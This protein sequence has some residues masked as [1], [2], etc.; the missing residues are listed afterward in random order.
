MS[1]IPGAH[2]SLGFGRKRV[3]FY[4]SPGV[5]TDAA[6]RR[7]GEHD[8]RD[9][10]GHTQTLRLSRPDTPLDNGETV[11]VLRMQS[12][13]DHDS[14]PVALINHDRNAWTRTSP[15]AT[16]ALGR[17]GVTRAVNWWLAMIAF[18]VA[19]L[20]FSWP[21]VR[22]FM[23]EVDPALFAS[24]PQLD[25]FAMAT[26][27]APALAGF[28]VAAA[29]PGVTGLVSQLGLP[30]WLTPNVL[31]FTLLLSGLAMFT[32]F[33]RSWRI[34]WVPVYILA[35][36]VTGLALGT[37]SPLMPALLALAG[38]ALVF[39]I[40]GT[41]NR[42]RDAARLEGRI[43]RLSENILRNPPREAVTAPAAAAAALAATAAQADAAE[44]MTDI[45]AEE[46]REAADASDAEA[47]GADAVEAD[48]ET[49]DESDSDDSDAEP[50]TSEADNEL[51]SDADLAAAR[52]DTKRENGDAPSPAPAL[53]VPVAAEIDD[54]AE[55]REM[56]LPPPPP[57]ANRTVNETG[58]SGEAGEPDI[59]EAPT[60]AASMTD[61]DTAEETPETSEAAPDIVQTPAEPAPPESVSETPPAV[62]ESS[63]PAS[64][65]GDESPAPV[66]A[67]DAEIIEV[68]AVDA[69]PTP[70]DDESD[71][72]L[73]AASEA[74]SGRDEKP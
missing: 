60:I 50:E 3:E 55:D 47:A 10:D 73:N 31:V 22:L 23:L 2:A 6:H 43:A 9:V 57:L 11:T 48:A 20:T 69:P 58:G 5:T 34:V 49:R 46:S 18:I 51:P 17:S 70:E 64:A 54:I 7:R 19:T 40:G 32:Y 14:R 66:A 42:T 38:V 44:E 62:E 21:D 26:A 63:E 59:A 61:S 35:A 72:F 27:Q 13:P 36:L 52:A 4:A 56:I 33:A 16:G 8:V 53:A 68:E 45:A 37:A 29:I 25:L 12:G 67:D 28:D 74:E 41:I 24:L 30:E 15:D 71:P 65:E 39:C 1:S